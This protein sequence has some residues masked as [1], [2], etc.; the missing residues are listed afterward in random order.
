MLQE[1]D[2]LPSSS[3]NPVPMD[4]HWFGLAY[5]LS[6]HPDLVIIHR[7]AFFHTVNAKLGLKKVEKRKTPEEKPLTPEEEME[8]A[9]WQAVYDECDGKLRMFIILIGM[10]EPRTKFLVYSRG[11]DTQWL[12]PGYQQEKW[13]KPLEAEAPELKGR[14]FTM[15]ISTKNK[16]GHPK[17]ASFF[18]QDTRVLLRKNVIE[19]LKLSKKR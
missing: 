5:V 2:L 6:K 10:N 17:E 3:L 12:E 18:N 1:E 11:T 19:I 4:E 9:K 8:N 15:T 7:S 13:I 16:D 14:I